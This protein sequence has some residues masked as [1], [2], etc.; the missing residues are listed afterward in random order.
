MCEGP[1]GGPTHKPIIKHR[2]VG[3]VK[4]LHATIY[5]SMNAFRKVK[6]YYFTLAVSLK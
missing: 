5:L 6:N 3:G 2:K 4:T 1:A